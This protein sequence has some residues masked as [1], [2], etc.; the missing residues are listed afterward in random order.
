M[1]QC[2]LHALPA[3]GRTLQPDTDH[4]LASTGPS[5]L[6]LINIPPGSYAY[7]THPRT[8]YLLCI[9]GT[10][11]VEAEHGARTQA[12]AGQ[13]IEIPPGLTHH[14]AAE[15]DAVIVTVAQSAAT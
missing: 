7:E 4:V 15:T 9:N 2:T 10:L 6:L 5:Q 13:M 12:T 14:F 8:E 3:Q 11:I 1:L